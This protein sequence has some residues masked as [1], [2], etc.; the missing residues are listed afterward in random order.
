MS[1]AIEV[2]VSAPDQETLAE[3]S[4]AVVAEMNKQPGLKQV[5]LSLIHI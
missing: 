1:S 3:A 4:E 5:E 2:A